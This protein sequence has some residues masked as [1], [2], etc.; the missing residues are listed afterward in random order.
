MVWSFLT[1]SE[2]RGAT[3]CATEAV[4]IYDCHFRQVSRAY[5]LANLVL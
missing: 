1:P 5:V 4:S 3:H 2:I